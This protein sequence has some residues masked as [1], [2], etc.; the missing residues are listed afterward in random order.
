MIVNSPDV[1]YDYTF[2][3][4]AMKYSK[5]SG[6][7]GSMYYKTF[8]FLKSGYFCVNGTW[9]Y[10]SSGTSFTVQYNTYVL[11]YNDLNNPFE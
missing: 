1:E 9:E 8:T 3:D 10:Y 5:L 7:P 4:G 6:T 2:P 11:Y